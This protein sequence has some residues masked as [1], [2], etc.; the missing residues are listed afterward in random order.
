MEPLIEAI[1]SSIKSWETKIYYST[2]TKRE[3][4][5]DDVCAAGGHGRTS[6]DQ[7]NLQHI[8]HA[9]NLACRLFTHDE[10]TS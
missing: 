7:K 5:H 10:T 1:P 3:V 9:D 6:S 4:S 2:V 8:L